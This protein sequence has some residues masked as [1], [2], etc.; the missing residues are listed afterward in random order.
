MKRKDGLKIALSELGVPP[1]NKYKD[2]ENADGVIPEDKTEDPGEECEEGGG[3]RDVVF[4]DSGSEKGPENSTSKRVMLK[5]MGT[6]GVIVEKSNVE[7]CW[8]DL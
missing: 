8:K 7:K 1:W 5:I 4:V 6:P 2:A 3:F